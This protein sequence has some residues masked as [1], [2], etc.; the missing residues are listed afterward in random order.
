MKEKAIFITSKYEILSLDFPEQ[1][2]LFF[3]FLFDYFWRLK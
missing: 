3:Y 1:T 2:L